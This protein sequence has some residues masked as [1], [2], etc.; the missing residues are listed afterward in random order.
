MKRFLSAVLA[1]LILL[2][3]GAV[4]VL[5]AE[6]GIGGLKAKAAGENKISLSWTASGAAEYTVNWKRSSSSAWKVAGT[7]KKTS[8]TVSGLSAGISYDFKVTAGGAES[9]TV[10]ATTAQSAEKKP[11]DTSS[12]PK[13]ESAKETAAKMGAGYNIGNTFDSLGTWLSSNASVS[14]FETAWGNPV[15]TEDY[16]KKLASLGFGAIRLPVTWGL[17]SDSSGNIRK[18]WLDRVQQVVD[19]IV[20]SGMYVIINVHHDTGTDGWIHVSDKS[21]AAAKDRFANIWKQVAE[22]FK[23]YGS[24]VLFEC[25]NETLNDENDWNSTKKAD[26]D[27]ILKYEQLFVDTVRKAGGNNAERN[28]IL[29]TYAASSNPG[30]INSFKLPKDTTEGHMMMEVHNYDPQGFTWDDA[31]WTTMRSTWGTDEDKR[32]IDNFMNILSAQAEKLGVPAI[33]GEFGSVDKKNDNERAE[34]AGYFVAAAKKKGI[35]CFFW[36][37]GAKFNLIDRKTCKVLHSSIV[38][39]LVDN[40]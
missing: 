36:D 33:V 16:I 12:T 4:D 8:A 13:I 24:E 7:T 2:G 14:Q 30:I 15:L 1:V 5:A 40:A 19:W 35:V 27:I 38:K 3:C 9:A 26:Y 10:T 25:F 6:A 23:D 28:L 20:D 22:R 39:A 11:A 21:Y 17:N 18:E 34:H 29:N 32:N 37:D 31:T